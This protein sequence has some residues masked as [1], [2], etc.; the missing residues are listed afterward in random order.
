M[1]TVASKEPQILPLLSECSLHPV[2]LRE[3]QDRYRRLGRDLVDIQRDRCRLIA[4][5]SQNVDTNLVRRTIEVEHECCRFF[6]LAYDAAEHR[7]AITVE[8]WAQDPA[9]DALHYSLGANR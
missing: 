9:L 5:F 4:T 6:T 2:A 3:Q 1:I 8:D 7:L